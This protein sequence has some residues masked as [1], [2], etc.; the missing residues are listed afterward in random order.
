MYVSSNPDPPPF[1]YGEAQNLTLKSYGLNSLVKSN[2]VIVIHTPHLGKN[3]CKI[4]DLK[5][6]K[7]VYI[8][9]YW[10]QQ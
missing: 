5:V 4:I 7:K 8:A 9:S 2:L 6:A 10:I 3:L 1:I